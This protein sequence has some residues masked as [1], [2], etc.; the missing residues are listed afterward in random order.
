MQQ[1]IC[2]TT[3]AKNIVENLE[4]EHNSNYFSGNLLNTTKSSML[5]LSFQVGQRTHPD[6]FADSQGYNAVVW[7]V[8]NISLK[9]FIYTT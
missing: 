1:I 2:L 3:T 7:N 5:L 8:V 6:Q 9:Y 4:I